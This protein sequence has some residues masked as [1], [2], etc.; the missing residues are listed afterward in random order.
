MR[1]FVALDLAE[2]VRGALRELISKLQPKSQGARWVPPENL[3]VTLKFIGHVDEE[4]LR[5]IQG[6][7]AAVHS[8]NP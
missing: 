3:H 7:L 5:P 8:S 4:K 1:L 2:D 6:A